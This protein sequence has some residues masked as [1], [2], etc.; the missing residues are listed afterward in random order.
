MKEI[1]KQLKPF[2][3]RLVLIGILE[4]VAA[5]SLLLLPYFMSNIVDEGI[6]QANM[7][8]IVFYSVVMLV[9][10]LADVG[11]SCFLAKQSAHVGMRFTAALQKA[12]FDKINSLT[13]EEYASIGSGSL[14]TRQTDDVALVG[15]VATSVAYF[16]VNIPVMFIG[17]AVLAFLSDWILS[18]ILIAVIPIVLLLA[19]PVSKKVGKLWHISDEMMDKQNAVVR[20][21]LTGIRVIRAFD[22]EAYEHKRVSDATRTMSDAIVNAN[23]LSGLI[24]P[25]ATLLLNIVTVVILYV[26]A[27]RMEITHLLSAGDI[28]ATVEYIAV[29]AAAVVDAS[30]MLVWVPHIRISL[31]RVGQ[32]FNL[33]S[34]ESG[35]PSGQ[36]L[37]GELTLSGVTFA[38]DKKPVLK[39]I[40]FAAK[41][42]EIVGVIGGTGSGKTTLV[43]LMLG[44]YENYEGTISLGG[45]DY[46]SLPKADVRDNISV[47][48]QKSMVFEGTAAENIRMSRENASPEEV[49]RAAAIAQI[50][51]FFRSQK[52]GYDYH[53]A[54]QGANLSGGQ[55]QRVNIA[56]TILKDASVYIF[57]D[58]FS[59][60]DFLTESKLRKSL[61]AELK[62][63][64]QIIITQRIAT[65]MHCDRVYVLDRG[66]VVGAGT[67]RELMEGC[68]I[69]R[70]IYHSQLGGTYE[71]V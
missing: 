59:A 18:L 25:V 12:L 56:R 1:L 51:E 53:L 31:G 63:K 16:V 48:L 22:R 47:A 41:E 49:S 27:V 60:L 64:T 4:T 62:G 44:F 69:Y 38:Y 40:D 67:H 46:K 28:I 35:A 10:A 58:S 66:S 29:M 39:G 8:K 30:W 57:D 2:L 37:S 14:L 23:V 21:R 52:E 7:E 65:A 11:I 9:I 68:E 15:D 33:K 43:K 26:G 6:A 19:Y 3:P 34:M 13:F 24:S 45:K 54:G 55:K 20:E 42:G 50:D 71:G 5:F 32:V 17:G 70:E 61:N 36:K